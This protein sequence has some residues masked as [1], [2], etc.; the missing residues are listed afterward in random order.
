MTK[1]T[2][3]HATDSN[4]KRYTWAFWRDPLR[5][6]WVLREHEGYGRN[7]ESRWIDSVPRI[8]TILGNYGLTAEV[9]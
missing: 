9:N 7:L 1:R 3:F 6:L 8:Q 5:N 4:G 2:A